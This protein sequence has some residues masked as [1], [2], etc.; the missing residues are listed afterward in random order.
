MQS[1]DSIRRHLLDDSEMSSS[2]VTAPPQT[3]YHR[4]SSFGRLVADHWIDLPFRPA[5]VIYLTPHDAFSHGWLPSAC[6]PAAPVPPLPAK[7][8][9][10][11]MEAPA[12]GKH[13]RG[14]RQRPWGKFAAEIRDPAKNGAR[15]WLGTFETAEEAA[16]AYDRAA[17]RMRGSRALLN[18]PQQISVEADSPSPAAAKRVSPER[19]TLSLSSSSS[20][21]ISQSEGST[22]RRKR[23]EA[24]ASLRLESPATV[25][26]YPD[27]AAVQLPAQAQTGLGFRGRTVQLQGGAVDKITPVGQLLVS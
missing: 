12:K 9:S 23:G 27:P 18:F 2:A 1:L 10:R 13:Y 4:T 21:P 5:I 19:S 7:P 11:E 14:V 3:V 22:K 25:M 26:A 17:Y 20:L 6:H 15:V 8:D 24:V 16:L